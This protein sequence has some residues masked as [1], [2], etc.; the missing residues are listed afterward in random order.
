MAGINP[1]AAD[2]YYLSASDILFGDAPR[3]ST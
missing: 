3:V 1:K 2:S